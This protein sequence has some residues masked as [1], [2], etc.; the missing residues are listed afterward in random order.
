VKKKWL[1][2]V[3]LALFVVITAISLFNNLPVS[4]TDAQGIVLDSATKVADSHVEF[5]KTT[6][7]D[8]SYMIHIRDRRSLIDVNLEYAHDKLILQK[9]VSNAEPET[10][11]VSVGKDFT[12]GELVGSTWQL[13][14]TA[15][16]ENKAALKASIIEEILK[17]LRGNKWSSVSEE[18]INGIKVDKVKSNHL[19]S[20]EFLY[21]DFKTGLPLRLEI[22]M[23]DKLGNPLESPERIEEYRYLETIPSEYL[24]TKHVV[25]QKGPAPIQRDIA[26]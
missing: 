10:I 16:L 14:K 15:S 20:V 24:N 8:G 18:I 25:I 17:K 23:K 22:F 13:S 19:E 9:I 2:R 26:D 7:L 6:L 12:S 11:I 4:H 21:F 5:I 1:I 3:V